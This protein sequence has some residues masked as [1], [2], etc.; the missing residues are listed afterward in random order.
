MTQLCVIP[1][2]RIRGRHLGDCDDEQC[3]GCLPRVAH[4]GLTCDACTSR[5]RGQLAAIVHLGPDARLV[6][7][8]LVRR[9]RGSSSGKPGSQS[10]LNDGAT[11]ALDAV[12]NTLTTLARTI[13]DVRG[14]HVLDARGRDPIVVTARWLGNQLDWL[15][16]AM[17]SHEPRAISAY[18]EIGDC[19]G[20]MR[21]LV[22]GPT[23]GRYAG[24]CGYVDE[25][26]RLCAEDVEAKY[27]AE[28]AVCKACGSEYDVEQRQAWMRGEIEDQLARPVTIAGVL[29]QLGFPIGYS[30]IAAYAAKGLIIAKGHDEQGK[31]RYR[32]GDVLATRIKAADKTS[33]RR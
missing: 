12:Q 23:P 33:R 20:R 24:P 11:D 3:A 7:A 21:G 13:A 16:H 17:D 15:R 8:G 32:I 22:N 29:L 19:A 2:C 25:D 30:T 14:L 27:G 9:G 10:P 26:D 4:D 31:P 18:A 5:A 28:V 6:A 1:T